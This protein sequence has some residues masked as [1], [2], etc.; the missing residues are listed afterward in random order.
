METDLLS[1][2][3]RINIVLAAAIALVLLLRA[4]VRRLCGAQLAYALWLLPLIAAAM[5][6]VP[7]RVEHV[8]LQAS[9]LTSGGAAPPETAPPYLLWAW[10][11]GALVSLGILLL[12]QLRFTHALGRLRARAD[13]GDR[14]LSAE[15]NQHGP[16]VIGVLR[17]IIVTPADFDAR[18][19]A[20]ERRIVLAHERAHVAQ[21]DPIAN[22][23]VL[24]LR[25]VNWFN[26][27]VHV[28][29]R[30]LRLDQELACDAAVLARAGGMRRRYAEAML[31]T[32]IAAAAPLGCAWPPANIDSLKERI[33]MLKQALPSRTQRL[34]GAS[35][36]LVVT[37]AAAAAAWA[38]QP[39]RVVT[40][41]ESQADGLLLGAG[42]DAE[43]SYEIAYGDGD[44]VIVRNGAVIE[45]RDLTPEE[46]AEVERALAEARIEIEQAQVQLEASREAMREA[47][48]DS[49]LSEAQREEMREAMEEAREALAESREERMHAMEEVRQALLEGGRRGELDDDQRRAVR[50]AMEEAREQRIHLDAEMRA[51]IREAM[52]EAR[53]ALAEARVH[54]DAMPH[55]AAALAEASADVAREAEA[56]RAAGEPERARELEEAARSLREAARERRV[57]PRIDSERY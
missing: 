40:S 18:F 21:G 32:H 23:I 20:E 14:V 28:G 42:A 2:L 35:A 24:L 1:L 30:A 43:S 10:A 33:A 54:L 7:G 4:P 41:I 22:A 12:R 57:E 26:P 5:C 39:A 45:E 15:T 44:R 49:R 37:A 38:A 53:E 25:C 11:A 56:A 6:F 50:E 27:L 31:K 17:P 51:E 29:A 16:A 9:A 3:V 8:V 34:L 46:R 55:I 52:E 47:M 36:I 19:D 13:L 48:R